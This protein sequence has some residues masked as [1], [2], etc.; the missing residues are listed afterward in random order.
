MKSIIDQK[1]SDMKSSEAF[2]DSLRKAAKINLDD[3]S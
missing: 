1:V 2:H 3:Y